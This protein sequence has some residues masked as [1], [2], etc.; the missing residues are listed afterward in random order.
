MLSRQGHAYLHSLGPWI[1]LLLAGTV[2]GFLWS[3]GRAFAGHRS[4]S[5][6]G[7]SLG[8]LWAICVLCLLGIYVAQEL[9]EGMLASGHPAGV[10]GVFAYGGW[11]SIPVAVCIGLV[12]AAVLHGARWVLEEV[13][14]RS[15]ACRFARR[16]AARPL[17]PAEL[18]LPRLAPL[19]AG[20]SGRGPP[21]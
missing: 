9:L 7:I 15:L 11:W 16:P 10:A 17:R 8:A 3:L 18:R 4:P 20:A 13:S 14:R 2:G 12:L 1:G 6:Y 21:G 5:R 19:A